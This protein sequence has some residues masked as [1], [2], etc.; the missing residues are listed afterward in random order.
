MKMK[1]PVIMLITKQSKVTE[2]SNN[3]I[4]TDSPEQNGETERKQ[5]FRIVSH[6]N[7]E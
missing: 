7:V 5:M 1:T 2:D 4:V 6:L 3:K